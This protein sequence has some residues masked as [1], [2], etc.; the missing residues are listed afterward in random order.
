MNKLARLGRVL[1]PGTPS[2]VLLVDDS[3][4]LQR[5]LTVCIERVDGITVEAAA[6]FAQAQELLASAPERFACAVLDLG[7]PDAPNGEVVDLVRALAIP[8]IVLTGSDD[9]PTRLRM[10]AANVIDYVVKGNAAEL[11]HVAYLVARLRENHQTKIIVADD[12]VSFR[13]YLKW[14]LENY[15][16]TTMLA[17]NGREALDLLE[18]NPDTSLVITDLHMPVMDGMDLIAQV[19]KDY[20]REDL[21][22]IGVSDGKQPRVSASMIKAGANDFI[23]KPFQIE[24]FYCRVTQNTNMVG[25]VRQ[26]REAATRDFLTGLYNRRHIF[27]VGQSLYA[28]ACR[29]NIN[30][31]TALID[32]DHFKRINDSYGHQ[33]GDQALRAMA[34][35]IQRTLR[36]GDV[37]G[38]YGGEE[39]VCLTMVKQLDHAP[40]AFERVRRAIAAIELQVEGGRVPITASVG[41]TVDRCES[42]EQMI[43]RADEAV[44]RAKESGRNRVVCM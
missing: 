20:R 38:R 4:S 30:L 33:V 11:E 29:G 42:L 25:Y 32:A 9:E 19:R 35:V 5:L 3:P 26:I 15:R 2:R 28:N 37:V 39:I 22:I 8:I 12:S 18:A 23:T 43:R 16:Y 24:E 21:A 41:V 7:L 13:T 10:Q 1:A 17:A 31:A 34:Q 6:S 14:L 27:E 36:T 44:Y 40:I